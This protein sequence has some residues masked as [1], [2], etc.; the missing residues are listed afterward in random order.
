MIILEGIR[1]LV[2]TGFETCRK[3]TCTGVSLLLGST[4]EPTSLPST[5]VEELQC[6]K[7]E[8]Q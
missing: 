7:G 4:H 8:R 5:I 3:W 6:A 1:Q 2:S